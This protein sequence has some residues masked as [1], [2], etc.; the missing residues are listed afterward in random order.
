M[1]YI[2]L[3]AYFDKYIGQEYPWAYWE[4]RDLRTALSELGAEVSWKGVDHRAL[5]D[6]KIQVEK[7]L[8]ARK[9]W[10]TTKGVIQLVDQ[11][12]EVPKNF[13][14]FLSEVVQYV[15]NK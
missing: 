13:F 6:S 8:E 2:M 11:F 7:L 5:S 10:E 12:D 3:E 1:D 15:Y 4:V 14:R 9:N